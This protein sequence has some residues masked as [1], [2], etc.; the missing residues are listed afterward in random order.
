MLPKNIST[1]RTEPT[2]RPHSWH[3]TKLAEN[4]PDSSMMQIS[5]GTI[6]T[7][8][9]QTYHSSSSTSDLSGYDHGYLRRSPD[10]YSSRGSMESLDHT[11]LPYHSCNLSP[12]KSTNSI[13]QLSHHHSKRDSAYSSFSTSSSIPEYP[14]PTFRNERS[15]S[16]ENMPSRNSLHEGIR[17]ADIKYV[18]TVYDSHRGISEEREVSCPSTIKSSNGRSQTDPRSYYKPYSGN[19]HSIGPVWNNPSRG[20]FELDNKAPPLPPTRSDSFM[21]IKSHDKPTS[22]SSLDGQSKPVRPQQKG[23]WPHPTNTGS[24]GQGH[25][26]KPLFIEGQLNTVMEK[27]PES[28]PVTQPKHSYIQTPQPGQ[29][30]LPTGIYPVPQPEP[31]YAQAPTNNSNFMLQSNNN[32]LY[33]ALSRESTLSAQNSAERTKCTPCNEESK[34]QSIGNKSGLYQPNAALGPD[35]KYE[36]APEHTQG[37]YGHYK[38]HV[39]P[40]TVPVLPDIG[41][42]SC[43]SAPSGVSTSTVDA[44]YSGGNS[45]LPQAQQ[46]RKSSEKGLSVQ[47]TESW[48]GKGQTDGESYQWKTEQENQ[49]SWMQDGD[50]QSSPFWQNQQESKMSHCKQQN[51]DAKI[52][53]Q[54]E[55]YSDI[56]LSQKLDQDRKEQVSDHWGNYEKQLCPRRYS[57]V[58]NTVQPKFQEQSQCQEQQGKPDSG[59]SRYSSSSTQSSQSGQ[60]AKPEVTKRSSVLE[61]VNMIEQREHDE[62]VPNARGFHLGSH[63]VR[64]SQSSSSRNS[65]NSLEDARSRAADPQPARQPVAPMMNLITA[66]KTPILHH[67]TC[68]SRDVSSRSE[69]PRRQERELHFTAKTAQRNDRTPIPIANKGPQLT[70]SRSSL[71]LM[72]KGERDTLWE[73]DISGSPPD[74]AFNRAYRNSLKDAQSKVLRATSFRRKDLDLTPPYLSKPK[75]LERPAS[76]HVGSASQ[77]KLPHAPRERHCVTPTEERQEPREAPVS[78]QVARIGGRRRLTAEQKKRSYS[79]P[80]KINELGVGAGEARHKE[81][82]FTFPEAAELRSVADRRRLFE[83]DARTLSTANLSRPELKQLQ[84]TAL[85]DYIHRKTGRRPQLAAGGARERSQSVYL[86][87]ARADGISL[88]SCSSLS[89]LCEAG[90]IA[91]GRQPPTPGSASPPPPPPPNQARAGVDRC[92]GSELTLNQTPPHDGGRDPRH[93]RQAPGHQQQQ[94]PPPF[95]RHSSARNSGK[96]A[97]ADNLLERAEDPVAVHVRSRSSPS[98]QMVSQDVLCAMN[99]PSGFPAKDLISSSSKTMGTDCMS[100]FYGA[101]LAPGSRVQQVSRPQRSDCS[102]QLVRAA[103]QDWSFNNDGRSRLMGP[104]LSTSYENE[105]NPLAV[106]KLPVRNEKHKSLEGYRPSSTSCIRQLSNTGQF[107][108]WS[109]SETPAQ[110]KAASEHYSKSIPSGQENKNSKPTAAAQ[111]A[112]KNYLPEETGTP[113]ALKKRPIPPQRPP[114]PKLKWI[115]SV[116]DDS[117]KRGPFPPIAGS[118]HHQ[119]ERDQ[120]HVVESDTTWEP[121]LPPVRPSSPQSSFHSLSSLSE[122]RFRSLSSFTDEDDVFIQDLDPQALAGGLQ[123]LPPPPPPPPPQDPRAVPENS[124]R[125]FPL[126]PSPI[127][128]KDQRTEELFNRSDEQAVT[129][130]SENDPTRGKMPVINGADKNLQA[131]PHCSCSVQRNSSVNALTPLT[132]R[133][134]A[135]SSQTEHHQSQSWDTSCVQTQNPATSQ[136]SSDCKY[137]S[138]LLEVNKKSPEDLKSEELAKQIIGKDKSLAEILD[139]DSNMKTTMDLMEGIFPRGSTVRQEAQH[140]RPRLQKMANKS[141]SEEDKKEEKETGAASAHCPTYYSTSALKAELMN[142]IRDM[143]GN[144]AEEEEEDV[145]DINEKKTELIESITHKIQTLREAK[146]SLAADIKLNSALGEEVEIMIKGLCKSNEF[147]KYKMFIGDLDKVVNLLLSLSGRLARVENVLKTLDENANAEERNLLNEKRRLLTSQHEDAKELKENLDRRAGVV[148]DIL[149]NYLTAEQLEDYQHFVKMKAALLMEQRELDDKIKLGE[150]QLKCLLESLPADFIS[151]RT[152]PSPISHSQP[153]TSLQKFTSSL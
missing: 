152:A 10:Q 66:D 59:R 127:T 5:Q 96:F 90:S 99:R 95:D 81:R 45:E 53:Q 106:N 15:Y 74:N 75:G 116:N 55:S 130:F 120:C 108:Y 36:M 46:R 122:S 67:L 78:Q 140:R 150:E 98:T 79:E 139:P 107:N 136:E 17:Q 2:A 87:Q 121:E 50:R 48:Q 21:A 23:T 52:S 93:S 11:N 110:D 145:P 112:Y 115:N 14:A 37:Q 3:S 56:R 76:A 39:F 49:S 148:L 89:S 51:L 151:Q 143:Q 29:P 26:L 69:D 84:Q 113:I 114:A 109:A 72:E 7:P 80:E 33:P 20:S 62:R 126:L 135:H 129:R 94:P 27:S 30:M 104:P 44:Q 12:A 138:V 34:D 88:S 92:Y 24:S 132:T 70:K 137:A 128:F 32:G 43:P 1:K 100:N 47:R 77:A 142:K 25:P 71:Q 134:E 57:E 97:S 119:P 86:Q 111:E 91:A 58:I 18:K 40:D 123:P 16:M 85:A 105:L 60:F 117:A 13:D 64:L 102:R 22:W 42:Q 73:D 31:R 6:S 54:W 4:Q 35:N 147:E 61:A 101:P 131:I 41:H 146:E 149:E 124:D 141:V 68:E 153:S 133:E 63:S 118:N 144:D 65:L 28:S 9:H 38:V 83:R 103:S 82:T 19:R 125:E 8:W